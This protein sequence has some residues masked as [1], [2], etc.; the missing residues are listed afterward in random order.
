M[1]GAGAAGTPNI[2]SADWILVPCA[3]PA[4]RST[5]TMACEDRICGGALSATLGTT[6]RAITSMN[7]IFLCANGI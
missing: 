5:M 2:C 3:K 6:A 7:H 4:D 1:V